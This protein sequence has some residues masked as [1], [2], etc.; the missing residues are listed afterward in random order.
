M[1]SV[2]E[3][4]KNDRILEES[5]RT[6]RKHF[7]KTWE[8]VLENG[9]MRQYTQ[10]E[11]LSNDDR[12]I[13]KRYSKTIWN[14][15]IVFNFGNV[16]VKYNKKTKNYNS[17]IC[18]FNDVKKKYI[19]NYDTFSIPKIMNLFYSFQ[20]SYNLLFKCFEEQEKRK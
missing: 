18:T 16:Y 20:K 4:V 11:Y 3:R 1:L 17:C 8:N 6:G 12:N 7:R 10:V 5:K 15:D 13:R 14:N 9:F 2:Q 19:Y